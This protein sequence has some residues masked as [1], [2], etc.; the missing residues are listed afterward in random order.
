MIIMGI[1]FRAAADLASLQDAMRLALESSGNQMVDALVT[2]AAK[3]REK[4]FRELAQLMGLPGLGVTQSNLAQMITPTQSQRIQDRFGTGSLAEAAA[5]VAAGP[6][7][8]LLAPRVVSGDG[9]ATAAIAQS[10][11]ESQS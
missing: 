6:D 5:L 9:K 2:E 3:S 1:G 7:A 4:V 11:K 10:L 8:L